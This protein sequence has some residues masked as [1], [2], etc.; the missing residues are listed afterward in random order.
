MSVLLRRFLRTQTQT[1][2]LIK[3]Y[4]DDIFMIWPKNQELPAFLKALNNHHPSIHFTYNYSPASVNFLDLTI[5]RSE[6]SNT[7]AVRTYQ[8]PQNLYQYLEYTSCHPLSI[9]KGLIKGECIRFARTNTERYNYQTLVTLLKKR[10]HT[11]KYTSTY[12]H[13]NRSETLQGPC[14]L[15]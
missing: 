10:K 12:N 13:K 6:N 14:T 1:P 2:I 4:I 9:Y 8:K 5:Y 11:S 15:V 3:H 7:L